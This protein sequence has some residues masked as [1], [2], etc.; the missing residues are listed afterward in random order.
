MS[1]RTIA[2]FGSFME[3]EVYGFAQAVKVADTI[4]VSGQTAMAVDGQ[5]TGKGDMEAQMR[6]AYANIARILA[7]LG[8]GL[9]DVVDET[10]FV[11]DMNAAV[12]CAGRV[13]KEVYD[14]RYEMASSLVGI[15]RLGGPDL[16][17]EIKCTARP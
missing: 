2:N 13:R 15:E 1:E 8:A 10:L 14:A 16:L 7:Q 3:G 4:Y 9:A 11:T 17:I 5:I 12:A 6:E